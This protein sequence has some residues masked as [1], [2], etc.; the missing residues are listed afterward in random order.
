MILRP[1]LKHRLFLAFLFGTCFLLVSCRADT[2]AVSGTEVLRTLPART[3]TPLTS[4]EALPSATPA[5][6]STKE[7]LI[8]LETATPDPSPTGTLSPTQTPTPLPT[9]VAV[10]CRNSGELPDKAFPTEINM[11]GSHNQRVVV[12]Y[13]YLYLAAGQYI[14]VFDISEPATPRFW[15]FWNFPDYP[16]IATLRVH[17]G[18]AYFTSGSKLV[19]LNL[20]AQCRFET[21]ATIDIPLEVFR[22]EIEKDRLYLGGISVDTKRQ[23]I[24]FSLEQAEQPREL[25][26]VDLG[27]APATWSV[28]EERLYVLASELTVTDVNDPTILQ[29]QVVNLTLDL[30]VLIYSPSEFFEDRLYLFSEAHGLTIIS[31][32]HEE[33]PLIKRNQE[34]QIIGGN[35]AY[36]IYQISENYIFLGDSRCGATDCNSS[37][38]FLD[39]ED[40]QRLSTFG[41]HPSH[42]PIRSYHEIQPDII[43]AFSDSSLLVI[44]V[45]NIAHPVVIAE[46]SLIK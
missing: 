25:G 15:G 6:E 16:D 17:N 41:V 2:P 12:S 42:Y 23:V 38:T 4:N 28:F 33:T 39:A 1:Y 14:G 21:I 30:Q 32:L 37:V 22:L 5:P 29:T 8:S 43:Y 13:P 3:I 7:E 36:F 11:S 20:S 24:I 19:L 46:V 45:S 9:V 34:Q 44:N 10:E 27:N 31:H 26:V 40:G 35:L 18:I